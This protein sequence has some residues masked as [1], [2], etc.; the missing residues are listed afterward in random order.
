MSLDNPWFW[1]AVVATVGLWKLELLSVFL[2]LSTFPQTVP[3]RLVGRMSEED[4]EKAREYAQARGKWE[5]LESSVM[6]GL[7]VAFWW[8]GGFAWLDAVLRG[9]RWG[10][11]PTGLALFSILFL[12]QGLAALPF[13]IHETFGIEAQFGFNRTTWGTFVADRLKGLA[14]AAVLGLPLLA[15]LLWLFSRV[16]HAAFWGWTAVNGFSLVMAFL[17]PRLIL[18]WFYR[19]WKLE[20]GALRSAVL[21]LAER[22]KFPV[23]EVHVVDG[24]RRSAK[25]NA[26]FTG[27]G[28][29]KRIALFDTLIEKHPPPEVLAVLAHEIGHQKR[30][31]VPRMIGVSLLTSAVL[32]TLLHFALHDPRIAD[33]FGVRWPTV[34]WGMVFFSLLVGPV[35]T[36]LGLFEGWL[37]RRHEFEADAFARDAVGSP[38]PMVEALLRLSKDHLAHPTPHPFHVA[39]HHSHPPV[40]AR[41]AAL[42]R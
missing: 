29:T 3:A 27:F 34:A 30:G 10:E 37:S 9:L 1:V 42:E 38:G 12:A 18:P 16:P 40:L 21:G 22:L 4:L 19:M 14:L 13:A 36:L 8:G 32:F 20:D 11:I 35:N 28:R 39:L 6:L 5:V 7:L 24:S 31:H 33:A 26:F 23:A 41:V 17:G 15:L 2:N 25:A